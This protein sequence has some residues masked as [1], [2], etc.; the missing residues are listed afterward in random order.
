MYAESNWLKKYLKLI[1]SSNA[2]SE[3]AGEFFF[4]FKIQLSKTDEKLDLYSSKTISI[5]M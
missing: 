1:F 3:Y 5:I 4:C 2:I